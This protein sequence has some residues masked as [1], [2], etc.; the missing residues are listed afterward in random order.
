MQDDY[1]YDTVYVQNILTP[2]GELICASVADK[3]V[4][5]DWFDGWHRQTVQARLDKHLKGQVVNASNAVLDTQLEAYFA[6]ERRIFDLNV[7]F[8]GTDFQKAVWQSLTEI[9]YG[10]LVTYAEIARSINR[11]N[12]VRAVGGAVGENPCSIVVPCH[13]VIGACGA[14]TGFGGGYDAKMK[15]LAIEGHR[16]LT[17]SNA[18]KCRWRVVP[19][20]LG[21]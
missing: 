14:I 4:C 9:P 5:C 1:W 3:L 16:I 8:L 6:H 17:D 10:R 2:A 12:A 11:P 21:A 18:P 20:D 15:L 7:L 13:R 19:K